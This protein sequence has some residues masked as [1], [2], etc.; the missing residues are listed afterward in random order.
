MESSI[1]I[2]SLPL[3]RW[4]EYKNI[5]LEALKHEAHAFGARYSEA[6]TKPDE[7]WIQR[8]TAAEKEDKDIMLFA[9]DKGKLVGMIGAYFNKSEENLGI[10]Y[11]WGVYVN[12][13]YRKKGIGKRLMEEIIER[14]KK[15]PTVKRIKLM[16]NQQQ[17]SAVRLYQTFGLTI[18]G[19]EK[20]M[21]GDGR[22]HDE[23]IMEKVL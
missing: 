3:S 10:G 5:R 9:Q 21:L 16:V 19:T 1:T 18:V 2:V 6:K 8:V 23:Y 7:E 22:E 12:K 15:M 4:E 17:K 14:L 11:I 13:Q 20:Y